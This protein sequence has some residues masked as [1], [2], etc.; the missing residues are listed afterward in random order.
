MKIINYILIFLSFFI[1]LFYIGYEILNMPLGFTLFGL[2][3][4]LS[5]SSTILISLNRDVWA[6]FIVLPVILVDSF[7]HLTASSQNLLENSPDWVIAFKLYGGNGMSQLIHRFLGGFL[8][9]T[10]IYFIIDMI[11]K[12]DKKE[13]YHKIY[14]YGVALITLLII[15][16]S[17]LIKLFAW[18]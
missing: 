4:F 6:K 9:I 7:F 3:L 10:T 16:T 11:F 5:I 2:I 1:G 12:I 13:I 15:T 14:L 18:G 8:L 17:Y